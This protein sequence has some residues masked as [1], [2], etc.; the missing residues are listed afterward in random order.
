MNDKL[1]KL[2]AFNDQLDEI[3]KELLGA[4]EGKRNISAEVTQE[5]GV[6]KLE[7]TEEVDSPEDMDGMP[8]TVLMEMLSHIKD[9]A[10]RIQLTIATLPHRER[11]VGL[12]CGERMFMMTVAVNHEPE[13]ACGCPE[14]LNYVTLLEHQCFKDREGEVMD[15]PTVLAHYETGEQAADGH[16]RWQDLFTTYDLPKLP[17]TIEGIDDPRTDQPGSERFFRMD[18]GISNIL[19]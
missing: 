15:A 14:W 1:K 5:G 4:D 18:I 12:T 8:L 2:Q 11:I 13:R 17:V 9:P 10:R 19:N 3:I 16:Q 7:I 6:T